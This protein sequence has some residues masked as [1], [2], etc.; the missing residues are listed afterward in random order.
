MTLD[1]VAIVF[2]ERG[3]T[4]Y[5][6][7]RIFGRPALPIACFLLAEGFARTSSRKKYLRRILLTALIA[8]LFWLFLWSRQRIEAMQNVNA[9]YEA[10]GGDAV[11]GADDGINV[12]Y[13]KLSEADQAAFT[14]WLIPVLNVLFTLTICMLMLFVVQ[15]IKD[16]FGELDP[17]RFLK[18]LAI[19]GSMGGTVMVTILV[20]LLF[21][22]EL[23]YALEAPLIVLVCYVFREEKKTK[24]VM[25][26]VVA[27]FMATQSILYSMAMLLGVMMIY[28]YNGE[29]GYDK[30]KK[31]IVRVLFY[32]YYP[33]HLA[34]LVEVR[35]FRE[36]YGT[37]FGKL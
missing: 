36:I 8:E 6:W 5:E 35:Y 16:R 14:D 4:L 28:S 15:K 27:L 3:S 11:Y 10:A 26:V 37:F 30:E 7:F 23:D 34:A 24:T 9:A 33:L 20:C 13:D 1:H 2:L 32:A 18:N 22:L 17:Q 25:L 31:P 29:L 12:W 19:I 21:P